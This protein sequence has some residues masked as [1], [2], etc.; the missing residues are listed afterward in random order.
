MSVK[1]NN[2]GGINDFLLLR[3]PHSEN[4]EIFQA[5][6]WPVGLTIFMWSMN[7]D[8]K[9]MI[10]E[11]GGD[12]RQPAVDWIK[13]KIGGK[14]GSQNQA[15]LGTAR[16]PVEIVS[17]VRVRG[18]FFCFCFISIFFFGFVCVCVCDFWCRILL[19]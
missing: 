8:V 11:G 19:N 18:S 3:F 9:T 17:N 6:K 13:K 2:I 16:A 5:E 14:T 4:Q 7:A 15:A 12:G 1:K 10:R